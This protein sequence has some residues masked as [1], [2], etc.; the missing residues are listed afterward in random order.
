[1]SAC[2]LQSK[3]CDLIIDWRKYYSMHSYLHPKLWGTTVV[4]SQ[5][6]SMKRHS[7]LILCG[8][9]DG[10]LESLLLGRLA[11]PADVTRY[12][13]RLKPFKRYDSWLVSLL[14]GPLSFS[15]DD[16]RFNHRSKPIL[17]GKMVF[18]SLYYRAI[19][20][21]QCYRVWSFFGVY[22][23]RCVVI[24]RLILPRYVMVC[25]TGVRVVIFGVELSS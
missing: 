25:S 19:I 8:R 2:H 15:A 10:H 1:M 18:W 20:S 4:W 12:N 22:I 23:T 5:Y 11:F 16:T 21:S 6:Y 24:C 3:S 14:F 17:H 9:Y 13:H 7:Q